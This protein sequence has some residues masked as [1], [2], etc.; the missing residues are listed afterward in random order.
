MQYRHAFVPGGW[1]FFTV[2][3]EKPR[4]LLAPAQ[5]IAVLREA[6][7]TVWVLRPFVMNAAV[8]LSDHLHC[9]WTLPPD[10]RDFATR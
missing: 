1:F 8:A 3:T 5:A 9:I 7:R 6:F 4:P 10:D 2:V